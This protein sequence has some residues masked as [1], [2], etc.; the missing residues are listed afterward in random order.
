MKIGL[1]GYGKMGK[2][3]E[4]LA[5]NHGLEVGARFDIGNPLQ[6][7]AQT[8]QIL[9]DIPVLIE[10][11]TPESVMHNIRCG[12]ALEKQMVVGTTGWHDH[13]DE[14][15]DLVEKNGTGL[16]HASNFSLGVN[17]FYEILKNAGP[18]M[19]RFEQYVPFMEEQHHQFKKDAP[20]GTAKVIRELIQPYFDTEIPISCVRAG[21]IPGSHAVVFDSRVDTIKLE[22]VARNR[23]GFAEGALIAARWIQDQKGLFGFQDI[24]GTLLQQSGKKESNYE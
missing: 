10:F 6:D 3:I 24:L 14:V 15:K 1:V 18:I 23:E 5:P 8:R 2:I 7:D 9:K 22:H 11:S 17:L 21:Y 12:L 16:V 19:A 4:S 20:S 13:I